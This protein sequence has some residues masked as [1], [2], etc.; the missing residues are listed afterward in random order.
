[1][2]FSIS[3]SRE[4]VEGR[5]YSMDEIRDHRFFQTKL[6][7]YSLLTTRNLHKFRYID[8]QTSFQIVVL[9]ASTYPL[10]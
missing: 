10:I 6:L 5:C 4:W 3:D 8:N 9:N 2:Y 1:M 7:P